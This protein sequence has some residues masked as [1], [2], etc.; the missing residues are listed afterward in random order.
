MDQGIKPAAGAM[1]ER[2]PPGSKLL[3]PQDP[4]RAELTANDSR[5]TPP[6]PPPAE[7]PK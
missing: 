6:A 4:G 2:L 1:P 3:G 7:A 5:V